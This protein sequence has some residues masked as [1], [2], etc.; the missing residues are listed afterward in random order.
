MPATTV[1]YAKNII[2]RVLISLVDPPPTRAEIN[3]LWKYFN[4]RCAY[5]DKLIDR[6]SKEG[7]IDHLV[8]AANGGRNCLANRVLS[9]ASCNEK[10]KLAR[11]WEP[12][13]SEKC[14]DETLFEVRR[15]KI[16]EWEMANAEQ[17][18]LSDSVLA[19][20][21]A[22]ARRMQA[23]FQEEAD[24]LKKIASDNRPNGA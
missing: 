13:L 19:T 6:A 1:S 18:P 4:S 23:H 11:P 12:F 7:H 5:C 9:C 14:G 10:E 17:M 20:A 15:E 16:C 8:P 22:A 21:E 3:L 2:R 24:Q